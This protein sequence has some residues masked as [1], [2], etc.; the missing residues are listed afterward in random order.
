MSDNTITKSTELTQKGID[1]IDKIYNKVFCI[2][3][4]KD[5]GY[6]SNDKS[7]Y[8]GTII[9]IQFAV[10]NK[11]LDWF[12]T[13]QIGTTFCVTVWSEDFINKVFFNKESAERIYEKEC[14]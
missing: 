2:F 10:R 8:E 7:M 12:A 6:D 14:L 3:S 11:K 4:N 5:F 1:L 9:S 13:I